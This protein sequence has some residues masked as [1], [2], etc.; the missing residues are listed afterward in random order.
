MSSDNRKRKKKS[1]A[2]FRKAKKSRLVEEEKLSS[3]MS[4]YFN[5]P[6]AKDGEPT[7]DESLCEDSSKTAE[8]SSCAIESKGNADDEI[9]NPPSPRFEATSEEYDGHIE[10][11]LSMMSEQ[12][13]MVSSDD[14]QS[15]LTAAERQHDTSVITVDQIQTVNEIDSET[16]PGCRDA[17][18]ERSIQGISQDSNN[19]VVK[20]SEKSTF[21]DFIKDGTIDPASLS[22]KK[23]SIDDKE[24]ILKLKPCQPSQNFLSKR[25]MFRGKTQRCCTQQAF[26]HNSELRRQWVSYSLS[27]NALFCIP[28][29]LFSDATLRGENRRL[30][31]GNAFT[32]EGFQNWKK[33]HEAL[34]KHERSET[35]INSK[36][37]EALFLQ[38]RSVNAL[39]DT[40][41]ILEEQRLR[42]KAKA[43]RNVMQRIVDVVMFLGR[44]GLALRGHRETLMHV[45]ETQNCGNFLELLKLLSQYDNTMKDHLEKVKQS[46]E[47]NF[48]S[49]EEVPK[50]K[51]R[52]SKLTFLSNRTQNKMIDIISS[53]IKGEISRQ[54][55]DSLAWALM[56][57]TTPDVSR[58][59]Q[60]SICVRIVHI[61]GSNSEHMLNCVKANGTKAEELFKVIKD[62]LDSHDLS[63]KKLGGQTYDGASNM[64]GCYNGLQALIKREIG[65]KVVYVHCYAHTLNLVLSDSAGIALDAAKL[66]SQLESLYLLFSRSEKTERVFKK[67]QTD[68]NQKVRSLKRINTV[69]WSSRELAIEVFLDRYDSVE[70]ALEAVAHDTSF[71]ADKRTK[72]AGLLEKIETKEFLATAVLFNEIFQHTGPLS[73]YLQSTTIDFG[74]ALAMIDGTIDQL[75]RLRNHPEY[76]TQ[77][78]DRNFKAEHINWKPIRIR[79]RPRMAGEQAAD[80]PAETPET[81]WE[82]NTFYVVMDTVLQSVRK[83]GAAS[84]SPC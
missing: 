10:S 71:D 51:G 4:A 73:R 5:K 46:Q 8:N 50:L 80:E 39:L 74:K 78:V 56:A 19:D 84:L 53:A 23:L 3:F 43:N 40:E 79:H 70:E 37:A 81:H 38:K 18:N 48:P 77:I 36:V 28:C 58:Q 32:H 67:A 24:M 15:E 57:D 25:K 20:E 17:R 2:E 66:F 65:D 49:S 41:M 63:F 33:Q 31:Q 68:R 14:T 82:R 9:S 6:K 21:H 52:G 44:Q 27:K 11:D 61:D 16:A 55:N 54:V 34:K 1:G 22:T 83:I 72:A 45:H 12:S 69:R 29:I 30:T 59:E 26:F 64:S 7:H 13:V 76:V 47:K 42:V 60:L 35:H 62:T 75:Q